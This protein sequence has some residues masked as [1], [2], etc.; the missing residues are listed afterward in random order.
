MSTLDER[1]KALENKAV[2]FQNKLTDLDSST[3]ATQDQLVALNERA[4]LRLDQIDNRLLKFKGWFQK[5]KVLTSLYSITNQ[6][7]RRSLTLKPNVVIEAP[8]QIDIVESEQIG[9]D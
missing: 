3:T 9:E 7:G 2:T 1:V 4:T 6:R 5:L 8:D